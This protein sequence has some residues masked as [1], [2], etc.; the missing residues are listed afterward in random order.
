MLLIVHNYLNFFFEFAVV[1]G[2]VDDNKAVDGTFDD[3]HQA[4]GDFKS[5]S[6]SCWSSKAV[7]NAVD[8]NKSFDNN[9]D[10]KEAVDDAD[11]VDD[12]DDDDDAGDDADDVDGLRHVVHDGSERVEQQGLGLGLHNQN[13][14]V[15]LNK[16]I[17]YFLS[18]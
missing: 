12:V 5:W 3:I 7:I 4:I 16:C 18:F 10:I 14:D 8:D 6:C 13:L 17:Q 2:A 1:D 9:D 15:D 11:D